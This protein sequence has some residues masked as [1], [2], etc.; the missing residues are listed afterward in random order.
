[1]QLFKHF[2]TFSLAYNTSLAPYHT[3][4]AALDMASPEAQDRAHADVS[5]AY[6]A[7]K[8]WLL[9]ARKASTEHPGVDAS[10]ALN[11]GEG[12]A[13]GLVWNELWPP[14]EIVLAAFEMD[15]RGGTILV[16][17]WEQRGN[18]C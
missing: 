9:L 11:D 1:M 2:P 18:E 6:A 8:L 15:A 10:G 4:A 5:H 14:F 7:I 17:C 12:P 16:R 13:A 3:A